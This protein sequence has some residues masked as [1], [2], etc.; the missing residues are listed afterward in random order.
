MFEYNSQ[1]Q[2]IFLYGEIGPEEW[3]YGLIDSSMVREALI[4][5]KG[6]D[7]EVHLNSPGGE[8]NEGIA[9]FNEFT[10]YKGDVHMIVDSM[11]ASMASY[12]LQSGTTRSVNA[13]SMIMVHDPWT[14]AA[15]NARDFRA[16]ADI[17]DKT[18]SRLIPAYVARSGKSEQE[19]VDIMANEGW[20]PGKDAIDAG[21][22][23]AMYSSPKAEKII[24]ILGSLQRCSKVPDYLIKLRDD[25]QA[26]RLNDKLLSAGIDR[27]CMTTEAAKKLSAKV[28]DM[29]SKKN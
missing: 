13:N 21:F 10:A 4:S 2:E 25:N 7:V 22:A 27:K 29:C 18:A 20:Y 17:L 19:I 8:V 24:P 12:I 5:M 14:L 28:A 23:D 15:G 9:I 26:A 6:K 3:G 1:T 11:A 16:I